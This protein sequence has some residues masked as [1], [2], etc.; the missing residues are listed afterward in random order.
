ME[1]EESMQENLRVVMGEVE[2]LYARVRGLE[3]R[4]GEL[5]G[6]VRELDSEN[7]IARELGIHSMESIKLQ[8]KVSVKKETPPP[9]IIY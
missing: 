2:G 3:K 6:R 7:R 4:N 9:S 8:W 1:D 5:E